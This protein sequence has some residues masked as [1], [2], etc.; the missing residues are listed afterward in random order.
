LAFAFILIILLACMIYKMKKTTCLQC[1][2]K[3]LKVA[4]RWC[5]HLYM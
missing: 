1:S 2:G 4:F 5:H 3:W